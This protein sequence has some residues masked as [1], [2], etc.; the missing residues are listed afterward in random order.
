LL[1]DEAKLTYDDVCVG[2]DAMKMPQQ[3][4]W[5]ADIKSGAFQIILVEN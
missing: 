2:F 4:L 1:T 5:L 3:Q